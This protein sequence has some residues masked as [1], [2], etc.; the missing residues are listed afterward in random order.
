VNAPIRV[1]RAGEIATVTLNNPDKLNALNLAMWKRLGEVMRELDA[2]KALRCVVLRGSGEKAFA[3]GA[4]IAEFEKT[5]NN[6]R[7]GKKYGNVL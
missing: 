4:D 3:A 1:D 5:R 6:S 7:S 2:D